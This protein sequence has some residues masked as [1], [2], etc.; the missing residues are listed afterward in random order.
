MENV[1]INDLVFRENIGGTN[2]NIM[3]LDSKKNLIIEITSP[4]YKKM[5]DICLKETNEYLKIV[6]SDV[7]NLD[8]FDSKKD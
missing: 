6:G 8:F 7:I 1:K 3:K 2:N 4:I 5:F